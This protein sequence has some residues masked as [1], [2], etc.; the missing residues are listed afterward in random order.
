MHLFI[1]VEKIA[2]L[3][4]KRAIFIV[5]LSRSPT[6]LY[7]ASVLSSI[8][9][10]IHAVVTATTLSVGGGAPAH[11]ERP[12]FIIIYTVKTQSQ[13]SCRCLECSN[14]DYCGETHKTSSLNQHSVLALGRYV[15]I[16]YISYTKDALW[17]VSLR[18]LFV[19]ILALGLSTH[20]MW[21]CYS[22]VT[23]SEM[24]RLI[25]PWYLTAINP[26]W[27]IRFLT[28]ICWPKNEFIFEAIL[29]VA[30]SLVTN[31]LLCPNMSSFWD[32]QMCIGGVSNR[33]R[34]YPSKASNMFTLNFLCV[35]LCSQ[36]SPPPKAPTFRVTLRLVN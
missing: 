26:T 16:V 21:F 20:E 23:N 12:T 24:W 29:I 34:F 8:H 1:M 6:A 19:Q 25:V 17:R 2:S 22:T 10:H 4:S 13:Q 3:F 30:M 14:V 15:H 32:L 28:A 18:Q 7:T 9:S 27:F 31:I 5:P 35:S 11:Q 36:S 33:H